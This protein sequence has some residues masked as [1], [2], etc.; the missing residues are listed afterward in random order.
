MRYEGASEEE[1]YR[2]CGI[3]VVNSFEVRHS[4]NRVRAIY[5][6]AAMQ[7]HDCVPNTK[8]A[9][10]SDLNMIL[11]ATVVIRKGAAITTTYTNTFWNTMQRRRQIKVK[12]AG[13]YMYLS[14]YM[15]VFT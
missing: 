12:D 6:Q 14:M 5:P 3:I 1:I 8:H 10:D 13:R 7:A 11:R 9:F 4:G 2:I 15:C